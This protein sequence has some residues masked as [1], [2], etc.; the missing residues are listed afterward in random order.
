[1]YT[2]KTEKR[3]YNLFDYVFKFYF[4]SDDIVRAALEPNVLNVV[5]LKQRLNMLQK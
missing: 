2:F 3:K 4:N 5:L 1:M